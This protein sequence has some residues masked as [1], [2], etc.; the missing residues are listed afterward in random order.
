MFLFMRKLKII[1]I[2][3]AMIVTMMNMHMV[4]KTIMIMSFLTAVARMV[5]KTTMRTITTTM[6]WMMTATTAQMK[7][8]IRVK[9]GNMERQTARTKTST[10]MKKMM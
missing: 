8:V 9:M 1:F 7:M 3:G 6:I 4:T 10:L 5:L 2:D